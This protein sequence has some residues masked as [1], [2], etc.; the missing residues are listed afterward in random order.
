[1]SLGI[2]RHRE[3]YGHLG[4]VIKS[5]RRK[6]QTD[7]RVLKLKV[8]KFLMYAFFTFLGCLMMTWR[9]P[10]VKIIK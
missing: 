6:D 7:I 9:I 4:M 8:T 5:S 1:V 3:E 10:K 2:S